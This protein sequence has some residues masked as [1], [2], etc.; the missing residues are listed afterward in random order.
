MH[1]ASSFSVNNAIYRKD[2][3]NE[4]IRDLHTPESKYTGFAQSVCKFELDEINTQFKTG[5]ELS[6]VS[7]L[8]F[9][10]KQSEKR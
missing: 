7:A 5:L 3:L 4:G 9:A 2:R 10:I 8:P 6:L 1:T